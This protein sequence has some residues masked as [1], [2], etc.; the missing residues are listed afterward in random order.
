MTTYIVRRILL[1]IPTLLGMTA[2]VFFIMSAAPGDVAEMLISR[3]GEMKAGDRAARVEYIKQRYGLDD[4]AM[5]QYFRWL[6]RIS[7]LGVYESEGDDAVWGI[8]LSVGEDE[9]GNNKRLGLKMPDFGHSFIHHRPVTSL[10]AEALPITLLLNILSLP[11]IYFLAVVSG[12]YAAYKRSGTFDVVSGAIMLALWSIPTIWAGVMLQGFLANTNFLHWF[13]TFGLH[14]TQS[15]QMPYLPSAG[16]FWQ[17]V[18]FVLHVM[19]WSVAV[20]AAMASAFSLFRVIVAAIR[21]RAIADPTRTLILS[22]LVM[23]VCVFLAKVGW[24]SGQMPEQNRGWL[25]DMGWHLVLPVVCLAYGSLAFMSKLSRSSVLENITADYV[26]TARAKGLKPNHV[27]WRHAF[28][29]SL[30]PMITVGAFLVPGMLG[31][32]IVVEVIFSINGMGKLL[33]SSIEF[34]DQEVVMAGTL[35]GGVLT[36][37]AYLLADLLYAVADPRVTYE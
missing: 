15:D 18:G 34:K 6:H 22:L 35:I 5:V 1:M 10:L 37:I 17:T 4:P 7:P 27:L 33:V 32:S 28:R 29:N 26:R 11:G 12:V 21:N 16:A 31:G 36:L 14:D 19:F 13:P 24:F 2:V 25:L 9:E 20:C 3:E 30:L 8:G 23:F